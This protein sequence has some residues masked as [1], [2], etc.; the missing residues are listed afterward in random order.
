MKNNREALNKFK[1]I[2]LAKADEMAE[3]YPHKTFTSWEIIA[4]VLSESSGYDVYY[5][6]L[7]ADLDVIRL[8]AEGLSMSSIAN[9]LSVKS[10]YVYTVAKTWGLDVMETTLDFNPLLIY[11]E[12]MSAEELEMYI[13]EILPIPITPMGAQNIVNN[14]EKYYDFIEILKEYDYEKG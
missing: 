14:I 3:K 8:I 9:R 1:A 12:G 4:N 6:T 2:F 7:K 11:K 10:M 5:L 13:N